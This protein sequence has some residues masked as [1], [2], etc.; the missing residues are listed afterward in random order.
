MFSSLLPLSAQMGDFCYNIAMSMNNIKV[1]GYTEFIVEDG[2]KMRKAFDLPGVNL[3]LICVNNEQDFV[4]ELNDKIFDIAFIFDPLVDTTILRVIQILDSRQQKIPRMVL[5]GSLDDFSIAAAL[6]VTGTLQK[7]TQSTMGTML[8]MAE[9]EMQQ[10]SENYDKRL[11]LMR[12]ET[13]MMEAFANSLAERDK[14]TEE[15][16]KR[17]TALA[18]KLARKLGMLRVDVINLRKGALLHDWGKIGIPD[19]ILLKEDKLTDAE[20]VIMKTHPQK[21]YDVLVNVETLTDALDIP[22]CHHEAWNGSGYPRGLIGKAIPLAARIFSIVDV[23]DALTSNR[24]YR[25]AWTKEVTL[26]HIESLSGIH[27][28]PAIVPIFIE[29]IIGEK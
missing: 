7:V 3:Q 9:M 19:S 8:R 29:M 26:A 12:G 16:T 18:V 28:D 23:Y 24:P 21:A 1:I 17:V 25:L 13:A 4:D 6:D 2:E 5:V 14:S 27:F 15:H 22:Y 20:W 10:A 11:K